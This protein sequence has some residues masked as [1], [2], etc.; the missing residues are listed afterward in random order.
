LE[1]LPA[2][3]QGKALLDA[4]RGYFRGREHLFEYCAVEIWRLIAPATGRC[5]VTRPS[6][7]GGRDAVGEYLLGPAADRVALEFALEAKCYDI[8]HSVGVR[9]VSRLIARLR[10]RQF[11]VFLTTS[12]FNSQVY[13]EVRSDRHPLV[14]VSGVDIVNSLRRVGLSDPASVTAWLRSMT[15]E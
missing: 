13:H 2:D 7:D 1:Q 4:V 11:G 3:G 8:T 9:D 14:L 5:D 6:R 12:Y 15:E 10:A